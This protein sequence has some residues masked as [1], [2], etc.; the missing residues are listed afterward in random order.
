MSREP[1]NPGLMTSFT[2]C[3]ISTACN[4]GFHL[5][6]P[7]DSRSYNSDSEKKNISPEEPSSFGV[8][9]LCGGET[10]ESYALSSYKPSPPLP[11]QQSFLLKE[12]F[13]SRC[14][15]LGPSLLKSMPLA[16]HMRLVGPSIKTYNRLSRACIQAH[17]V[18]IVPL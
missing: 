6:L 8:I 16:S 7:I 14:S 15:H 12:M 10:Q 17:H 1:R 2:F 13:C 11:K 18:S 3:R 5:Q 4:L 9:Q